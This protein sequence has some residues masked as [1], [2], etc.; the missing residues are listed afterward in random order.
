MDWGHAP[1]GVKMT[2]GSMK[3]KAAGPHKSTRVKALANHT[4][5]GIRESIAA[6][7]AV[8]LK[9][10]AMPQALIYHQWIQWLLHKHLEDKLTILLNRDET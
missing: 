9:T 6:G 10:K 8:Q 1:K 7:S 4:S 3:R 2:V 5:A